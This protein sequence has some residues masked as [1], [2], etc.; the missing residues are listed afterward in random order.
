MQLLPAAVIDAPPSP[1][2]ERGAFY[3][4]LTLKNDDDDDDEATAAKYG[5]SKQPPKRQRQ[6]ARQCPGQVQR[7]KFHWNVPYAKKFGACVFFLFRAGL[8]GCRTAYSRSLQ[9]Q[10]R[11]VRSCALLLLPA[12]ASREVLFGDLRGNGGCCGGGG[13]VF[14]PFG[15]AGG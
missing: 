10:G 1:K 2:D 8:T 12:F 7:W 5:R 15:V 14:A 13:G 3:V 11:M 9:G 4:F 6:W